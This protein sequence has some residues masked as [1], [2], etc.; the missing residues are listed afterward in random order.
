MELLFEEEPLEELLLAALLFAA[1]FSDDGLLDRVLFTVD[2]S[3][4]ELFF[5]LLSLFLLESIPIRFPRVVLVFLDSVLAGLFGIFLISVLSVF[6]GFWILTLRRALD[7][8]A[9]VEI[10]PSRMDLSL[11][12][13]LLASAATGCVLDRLIRSI[14]LMEFWLSATF[15]TFLAPS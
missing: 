6:S 11:I 7:S 15:E 8:M 9:F 1:G 14:F 10:L 3:E 5:W 12:F 4:E 13:P 2:S